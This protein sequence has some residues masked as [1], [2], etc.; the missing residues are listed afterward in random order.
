[1]PGFR[2]TWYIVI[3]VFFVYRSHA[4]VHIWFDYANS[5]SGLDE[6]VYEQV[7][8]MAAVAWTREDFNQI[9]I[10]S[11]LWKDSSP[12]PVKSEL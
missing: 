5:C 4:Q 2:I 9:L 12:A 11:T 10:F 6:E 3:W 8:D 7:V 1:M